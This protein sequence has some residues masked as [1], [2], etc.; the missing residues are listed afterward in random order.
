M[1]ELFI[2]NPVVSVV[3]MAALV[4]GL[5]AWVQR[6]VHDPVFSATVSIWAEQSGRGIAGRR[7]PPG[8]SDCEEPWDAAHP[9]PGSPQ[10][11][12][13]DPSLTL[14]EEA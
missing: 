1:F 6:Y 7:T 13:S 5:L 2:D 4:W 12:T 14:S 3:A 8:F 11:R 9:S 10:N